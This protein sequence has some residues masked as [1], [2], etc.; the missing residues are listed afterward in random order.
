VL[1]VT[2]PSATE[3]HRFE[4]Q[5]RGA[6]KNLSVLADF[7]GRWN[8][9][10]HG[11]NAPAFPASASQVN[12][13]VSLQHRIERHGVADDLVGSGNLGSG[14]SIRFASCSLMPLSMMSAQLDDAVKI[15]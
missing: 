7:S 3:G 5:W 4:T 6:G 10:M 14:E 9:C 11:C 1:I 2:T 13:M 12:V 15:F 8:D